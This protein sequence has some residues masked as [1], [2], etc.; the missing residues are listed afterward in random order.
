MCLPLQDIC[1]TF[2]NVICQQS[3]CYVQNQTHRCVKNDI[4]CKRALLRRFPKRAICHQTQKRQGFLCLTGQRRLFAT[5]CCQ[6]NGVVVKK[7]KKNLKSAVSAWCAIW[8]KLNKNCVGGKIFCCSHFF[9]K[10]IK[11][12]IL[13]GN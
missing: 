10:N 3:I 1:I 9:S 5:R 11:L 12:K 8:T 2:Q 13:N 4:F 6:N 7:S